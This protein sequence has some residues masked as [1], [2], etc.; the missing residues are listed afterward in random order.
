MV[1]KHPSRPT[2]ASSSSIRTPPALELADAVTAVPSIEGS[3]PS[4]VRAAHRDERLS[5]SEIRNR[6]RRRVEEATLRLSAALARFRAAAGGT[7]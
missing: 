6:F 5:A 4:A 3:E 1:R 2:S 7:K